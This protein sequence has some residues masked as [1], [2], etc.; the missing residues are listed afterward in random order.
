L[1]HGGAIP[2]R[3]FLLPPILSAHLRQFKR[4]KPFA[5]WYDLMQQL[6]YAAP[7]IVLLCEPDSAT[8]VLAAVALGSRH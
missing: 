1:F 2:V 8:D 6:S 3:R 5:V 4:Y 7:A